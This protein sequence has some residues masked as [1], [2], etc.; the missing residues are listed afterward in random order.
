M[1]LEALYPGCSWIRNAKSLTS[2]GAAIV[3]NGTV[4]CAQRGP[5]KSLAGY[6]NSWRQ[7]R[8][9]WETARQALHRE[10]EEELLCEVE[11]AGRMRTS[12]YAY[13]FGTVR[14]TTFVCHLI[15]G[16]PHLTEHTDIRWLNPADMPTLNWAPVDREAVAIIANKQLTLR[17]MRHGAAMQSCSHQQTIRIAGNKTTCLSIWPAPQG[18]GQHAT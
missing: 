9:S 11:V 13:D 7:N 6:W 15:A 3:T 18:S 4:L 2:L 17:W 14:L 5:G 16:T 8:T 1:D 10:I 12:E